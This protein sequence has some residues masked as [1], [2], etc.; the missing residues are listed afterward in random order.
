M[1]RPGVEFI[2]ERPRPSG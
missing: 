1:A 2:A